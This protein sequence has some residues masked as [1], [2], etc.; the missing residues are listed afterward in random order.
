MSFYPSSNPLPTLDL[1][2]YRKEAAIR[3]V[4]EFLDRQSR[5]NAPNDGWVTIITGAGSHSPDGPVLRTAVES[6]LRR[7]QIQFERDTPGPSR[8][9]LDRERC[10]TRSTKPPIPNWYWQILVILCR[11]CTERNNS[12]LPCPKPR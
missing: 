6:L 2:G 1:H 11:V 12:N 10:G 8:C 7:R 3:A 9:S 5:R 4:T